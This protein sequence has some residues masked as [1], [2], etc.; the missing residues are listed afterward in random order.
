MSHPAVVVVTPTSL[1]ARKMILSRGIVRWRGGSA[2]NTKTRAPMAQTAVAAAAALVSL[3]GAVPAATA[4]GGALEG[5]AL[6]PANTFSDGPTTGQFATGAGGNPLPLI[7]K[8]AVQGFSAV[9]NG[10]V[11]GSYLFM[12][13]NGFGAQ[14]N[15]ADAL[16]RVYGVTPDF[17]TAQGGSGTVSAA[18]YGTGATLPAFNAASRITLADPN[19]QLGFTIQADY[20]HYYNVDSNP[21]VDPS[22]RAGRLLTGADFDIESMRKDK[23]GNL[24]FGEEFGPFLVKTSAG[25]TVLRGELNLPGV[26]A[27]QN[28]YLN[29]GTA[30]LGSSRGFEGM[31]I[32]PAGDRLFTLL[33]GTVTGD[34]AGTLRI[35]AFNVDTESFTDQ[36]WSYKLDAAGTNIGDMTA[37]NDHEFLV[38]ERNGATATSGGTPFKKVFK[39]DLNATDGDGHVKKTELVDLM[40]IADPN[41]LNGDG[42]TTFTFPFVT[43][44]SV[45][46]LDANTLL[47]A[48]DNNYPGVG[49]RDLNSD[50][51]EFLKI[52][53]TSPVPEPGTWALM[54][55]GLAGVASVS[56]RPR[57]G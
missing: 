51:T 23:N 33:E 22:I 45:L 35:N 19:R 50:N 43:I 42:K 34:P 5:W 26:K 11:A 41:D 52:H 8:Q 20:T 46:V 28:P 47:L 24:W 12:P 2:M 7:G 14:G 39:I 44:E 56:R 4:A 15:S 49:G 40:N 9:L 25:G 29:G 53:L 16:L 10:A 48:N 3:L 6:M 17:K 1:P 30:N 57:R 32:N 13:D 37:I 54:L 31:A 36:Q 27:P 21:L 38:I 18:S 55:A